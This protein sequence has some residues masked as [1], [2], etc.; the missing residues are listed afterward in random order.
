MIGMLTGIW[1]VHFRQRG[2]LL[3]DDYNSLVAAIDA[4]CRRW[5][6]DP[7]VWVTGSNGEVVQSAEVERIYRKRH[8]IDKSP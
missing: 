6:Q 1:T 3:C 7:Q 5:P 8:S 4:A 2:R